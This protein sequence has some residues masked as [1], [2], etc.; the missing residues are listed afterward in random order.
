M[1]TTLPLG[2]QIVNGRQIPKVDITNFFMNIDASKI[3]ISLSGSV[4]ADIL[5]KI[6]WTFKAVIITVIQQT[7]NREIPPRLSTEVNNFI[8]QTNGLTRL[9][10]SVGLD[11]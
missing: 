11:F 8:V 5:D 9:F 4:I 7:I 6:I 1:Q 10:D 2:T 3:K